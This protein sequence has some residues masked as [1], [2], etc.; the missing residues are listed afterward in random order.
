MGARIARHLAKAGPLILNG[1]EEQTVFLLNDAHDG[2]AAC[3]RPAGEHGRDVLFL[4]Q[5]LNVTRRLRRVR[6]A[7]A[8]DG[9]ESPSK[10]TAAAVDLIDGDPRGN[11]GR[12]LAIIVPL[13]EKTMP[14]RTGSSDMAGM[15]RSPV[16][17]SAQHANT[18]IA[19]LTEPKPAG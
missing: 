16:S 12:S 9:L 13:S 14:M 19:N 15:P 6:R 5:A 17:A 1:V 11:N 4:D 8:D 18:A 3:R 7:I 10:H 2:L